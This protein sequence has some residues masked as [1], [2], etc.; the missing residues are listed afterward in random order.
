LR[1]PRL[2]RAPSPR[3]TIDFELDGEQVAVTRSTMLPIVHLEQTESLLLQVPS[4]VRTQE[5]RNAGFATGVREWL[6][7]L[8]KVFVM[9]RLH[10]SGS[11][12]AI[13]SALI[14]AEHR[15]VPADLKFRGRPTRWR[16]LNAV[17]SQCLGEAVALA[18]ALVR[19]HRTRVSEAERI[20]QQVIAAAAAR[21]LIGSAPADRDS[22]HYLRRLR[23]GLTASGDLE[24][25]LVHVEGL[26]GPQ[27]LLVVL[28]RALTR[29][30]HSARADLTGPVGE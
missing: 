28:E 1:L 5:R 13:R 29:H 12:A 22:T 20:S 15:Q 23:R 14:A 24:V 9:N 11:I 19:E 10:Q 4:L 27:D 2:G 26:V 16:I 17:A 30:L 8:E 21:D 25:A 3:P 7:A 18:A 6:V